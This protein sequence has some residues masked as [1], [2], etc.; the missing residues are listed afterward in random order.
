MLLV[1]QN[2]KEMLKVVDRIYVLTQGSISFEGKPDDLA[3]NEDL[4][5]SYFGLKNP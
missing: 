4:L 5:A 1:D 2:I 3:R